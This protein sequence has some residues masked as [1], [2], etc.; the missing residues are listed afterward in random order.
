MRRGEVVIRGGTVEYSVENCLADEFG[1]NWVST[2][3]RETVVVVAFGCG[4]GSVFPGYA[5]G[6]NTCWLRRGERVEEEV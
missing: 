1:G 3:S 5:L 2:L 4:G 6:N